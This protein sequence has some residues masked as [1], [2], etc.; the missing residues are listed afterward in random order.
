M[1]NTLRNIFFFV[2]LIGGIVLL[3]AS[4]ATAILAIFQ[5][6]KPWYIPLIL[7][8]ASLLLSFIV[9]YNEIRHAP[10]I[11]DYRYDMSNY[12]DEELGISPPKKDA[13]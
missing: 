6:V 1:K 3:I 13:E 8:G 11:D 7:F 9:L 12:S 2:G 5:V 10:T 4:I